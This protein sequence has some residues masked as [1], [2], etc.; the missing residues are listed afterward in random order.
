MAVL[1]YT[2][3][4]FIA[5]LNN[6][7]TQYQNTVNEATRAVGSAAE[8]A[9][10]AIEAVQ[11]KAGVDAD[12]VQIQGLKTEINTLAGETRDNAARAVES[13]SSASSSAAV[14]IQYSGNPARPIDGTWWIWDAGQQNYI[15]TGIK[16]VL[17]ITQSYSSV[18]E[19]EA[20]AA[21]HT[22]GDL[23]IIAS[24][25]N[26]PDNS[27]LFV[28]NGVEW[29]YLSDL[30]GM[31]GVGIASI[32][33]TSGDHSAG[34]M[35]TYT[36]TL[37]D[38]REFTIE[39]FNGRDGNGVES[40]TLKSGNHASGT[41]DVY[42]MK[43]T[44]GS[45]VEFPIH[46]GE[47]GPQGPQGETG[48]QGP[49]GE[50][51]PQGP[52]GVGISSVALT[53]GTH[54]PGTLDTYTITF[55]N[56][57]K[58]TFDVYNGMDGEAE[59][60]V[61]LEESYKPELISPLSGHISYLN[62]RFLVVPYPT[63]AYIFNYS[64]DGFNWEKTTGSPRTLSYKMTI[65]GNGVYLSFPAAGSTYGGRSTNGVIWQQM[66][67][68]TQATYRSVAFG[69]GKFILAREN[70]ETIYSS[71]DGL[72]WNEIN[73]PIKTTWYL[74]YGADKFV[75]VPTY[76]N[77][78]EEAILY[79]TDG[80][81]WDKLSFEAGSP[82]ASGD[83][84]FVFANNRF[85]AADVKS[86]KTWYSEDGLSWESG[87]TIPTESVVGYVSD[88][89]YGNGTYVMLY[90]RTN[91]AVYSHDLI[92]WE[93]IPLPEGVKIQNVAFGDGKFV[94]SL[95]GTQALIFSYDGITWY[96]T[97]PAKLVTPSGKDITEEVQTLLTAET[98][99][100]ENSVRLQEGSQIALTGA[101]RWNCSVFAD[102]RFVISGVR[103]E[104]IDYSFDGM[105]WDD[106]RATFEPS[107][108][109]FESR[110][111]VYGNGVLVVGGTTSAYMYSEDKGRTWTRGPNFTYT[112]THIYGFGG[113][114]FVAIRTGGS[115]RYYSYDGKEWL[116][117][118]GG[119][120]YTWT[121]VTYGN[122]Q[123]I[124]VTSNNTESMYSLD[125][126]TW[127]SRNTGQSVVKGTSIAYGDDKFVV[128]MA[129][130]D[131]YMT[132]SDDGVT[133]ELSKLPEALTW[134]KIRY[135]GDAF[136]ATATGTDRM[137]RS[138]DGL[139]WEMIT[140]PASG[141]WI[142]PA[143]GNGVYM[144]ALNNSDIV[145]Y[146]TDGINWTDTTPETLVL[147]SGE[148]VTDKIRSIVGGGGSGGGD[149][150]AIEAELAEVKSELG[151]KA[152]TTYVDSQFSGVSS[153]LA[154]KADNS[155]LAAKAD[156]SYVNTELAKKA[157]ATALDSKADKTELDKYLPLTGGTLT[158]NLT[159]QYLTG[160]WVKTTSTTNLNKAPEKVAVLD[161]SGW[162]YYRTPAEL[163]EDIGAQAQLKGTAGQMVGFDSAGNAVAQAVPATGMTQ[164]Q[165]DARYMQR[166]VLNDMSWATISKI[167]EAGLAPLFWNIG[168]E[169]D[170]V[171][172]GET[173]TLQIYDFNHDDLTG[174][175]KAGITFGMKNLMAETRAM[176]N[177]NT[178][179]GG[180]T[181]SV[182]Y[183]WMQN[184]LY[185]ALP[186]ELKTVIKA[187]YKKTSAGNKSTTINTDSMK[188]FLFSAIENGTKTTTD[189]YKEEG[190]TYPIFT[191]SVSRIK[192][193]ANGEGSAEYWWSRSPSTTNSTS[194]ASIN[195][196]GVDY[197][198]TALQSYGVCFGFCV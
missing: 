57:T 69:A 172:N 182:M 184:T 10:A 75:A 32:Q 81:E 134:N 105:T 196:N 41:D 2:S 114:V 55:S 53:S 137:A 6:A 80:T 27:K 95:N 23:V 198:A 154:G 165:A 197:T 15:D 121:D 45:E 160:T 175:G 107:T 162:I 133:W 61:R 131:D 8:A 49:Q 181:G 164:E 14:A 129:N 113:G 110:Q 11:A 135:C 83:G 187:V 16:S 85:V 24:T 94:A 103:S 60:S 90:Q 25:P 194:F 76:S 72:S 117:G 190:E 143:Y 153:A 19:M 86:G 64:F 109:N 91:E 68:P 177:S 70:F 62:D 145:L 149:T 26:D 176:N 127:R 50:V 12:L 115:Q 46:N 20:D 125:G 150:S 179:V 84:H 99:E 116:S 173:L 159:G 43:F 78:P 3:E 157:D 100:A 48:E 178:N 111:I 166:P 118:S 29:V 168:D 101:Q 132:S 56:G 40:V 7:V 5:L 158:G 136:F 96:D 167:S 18:E 58:T 22:D 171:V 126:I 17:S 9:K 138:T 82:H 122:G 30:S 63:S 148:D 38:S 13:A 180:F 28:H 31:E 156:T 4:E 65:Y 47:V 128:I 191:D 195:R 152:D 186:E 189:V 71:V 151:G 39:V 89:A 108:A 123:F 44:D 21:S 97:V 79:S 33:L 77:P 59:N 140:L 51:G 169:K 1:P 112:V 144:T 130:S 104:Y 161:T 74:C 124:A 98:A 188:I 147:K 192:N 146:S 73:L 119:G 37:T 183:D 52:I 87:G 106:N 139:N 34:T 142:V 36:I 163:R 174:G 170:I 185:P 155:A 141:D 193:L 120:S 92:T 88:I 66:S 35:D 42:V 54:A 67:L 93:S 102:D